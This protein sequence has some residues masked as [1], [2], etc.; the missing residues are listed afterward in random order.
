MRWDLFFLLRFPYMKDFFKN[1]GSD[2]T[3]RLGFAGSFSIGLIALVFAL[4]YYNSLPPFIPIFNQL[5]WGEQRLGTISTI[6]IPIS[7]V[8]LIFA[9]NLILALLVYEKIPLASRILAISSLT[10]SILVFFF[11][12]TTIQLIL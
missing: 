1:I 9:C 3:T 2:K 5:P 12:I 6:F 8:F 11:M 10:I 4:F 7:I